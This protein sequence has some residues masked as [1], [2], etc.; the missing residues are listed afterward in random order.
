LI[1]NKNFDII[2][3]EKEKGEKTVMK[4]II[5]VN[6]KCGIADMAGFKAKYDNRTSLVQVAFA[7]NGTLNGGFYAPA[8]ETFY[9]GCCGDVIPESEIYFLAELS[10]LDLSEEILGTDSSADFFGEEEEE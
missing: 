9:C 10:W 5:W 6:K 3:I 7:E 8:T 1:F 4:N 2:I